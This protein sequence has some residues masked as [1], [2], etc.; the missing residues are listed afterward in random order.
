MYLLKPQP[1][2][3]TDPLACQ[4]LNAHA[5]K[6]NLGAHAKVNPTISMSGTVPEM[7]A[8]LVDILTRRDMD[9]IVAQMLGGHLM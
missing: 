2:L 5:L 3:V 8:R 7:V 6:R 1:P 4:S 9:F